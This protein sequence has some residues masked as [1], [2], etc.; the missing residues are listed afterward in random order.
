[1][2]SLVWGFTSYFR[3]LRYWSQNKTLVRI[4]L[5][6][7]IIDFFCLAGGLFFS[8]SRIPQAVSRIMKS[9]EFWY[10]FAL[11]YLVWLLTAL[12]LLMITLFLVF[13]IANLIT[14]PF[15]D[16]LAE[17]TL[18]MR[19]VLP[20]KNRGFKAWTGRTFKNLGAM[21]R[22]TLVLLVIGGCLLLATLVPGVGF[23]GALAGLFI[24]AFDVLDYSFDQFHY[25]FGQR[26]RF[27]RTHFWAV[28]GFAGGLGL[29]MA[30]PVINM[31]VMPASAVA[32][33]CFF[34][35]IV[36]R[37]SFEGSHTPSSR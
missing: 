20:E 5:V 2:K 6:P 12:A 15:N 37:S 28:S 7:F 17:K 21:M 23:L 29:T 8:V 24:M 4:S 22:K 27:V 36:R 10:Q 13:V 33:A 19:Q 35:D 11:Y 30:I 31:V 34:A 25:S 9:P 1:M 16:L 3:G 18:H 32:G 26:M 14:F